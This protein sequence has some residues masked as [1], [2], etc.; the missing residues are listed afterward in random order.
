M[1]HPAPIEIQ[2]RPAARPAAAPAAW[3]AEAVE[4]LFA[5]PFADLLHRAQAVHRAHFD[6]TEVQLSTLLSIKTG[7]C[8]EDCAYCPQS[9]HYDTGVKAEKLM[10]VDAVLAESDAILV[11]AGTIRQD[12]P[13]LLVRSQARRD[14][15]VA[16]GLPPSPMKVTMTGRCELDPSARFFATGDCDKI[17]YC[18]TSALV[19]AERRLG[20]V[21]TVVDAGEL[22]DQLVLLGLPARWRHVRSPTQPACAANA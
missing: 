21:A 8:P 18:A 7:G 11:G 19:E 4:A 2:R 15:R 16:R 10:S 12:N 3:S 5:L 13:R 20:A 17:V 6:A 1:Q 14:A 22:V 9:V